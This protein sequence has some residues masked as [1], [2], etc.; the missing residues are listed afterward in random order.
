MTKSIL[1]KGNSPFELKLWNWQKL[2]FGY[3]DITSKRIITIHEKVFRIDIYMN[4]DIY[5]H[6]SNMQAGDNCK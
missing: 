1:I 2:K 3:H 6:C 4:K 5:G